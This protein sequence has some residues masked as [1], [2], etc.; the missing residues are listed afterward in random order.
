MPRLRSAR[1]VT[2]RAHQP[3]AAS[4]GCRC[5]RLPCSGAGADL[6][7]PRT[8]TAIRKGRR[9][10]RGP[11]F[12]LQASPWMLCSSVAFLFRDAQRSGSNPCNGR[13][14]VFNREEP[15]EEPALQQRRLTWGRKI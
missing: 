12:S 3:L 11:E 5:L 4:L 13:L 2:N 6:T 14:L 7:A 10:D 1:A 8:H 15:V 9:T